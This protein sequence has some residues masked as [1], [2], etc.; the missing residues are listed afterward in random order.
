MSFV[1]NQ[2][3]AHSPLEAGESMNARLVYF[4]GPSGAGKDSLMHW[5]AKHPPDGQRLHL[6]RRTVTRPAP[7]D[8]ATDPATFERLRQAGA[9]AMHW[10]ANGWHYGVRREHLKPL[11]DGDWVLVSGSRAHWPTV[12]SL[13]PGLTGVHV[14][15]SAGVLRQR[16]LERGRESAV[17][18]EARIARAAAL[19]APLGVVSVCNNGVLAEAGEALQNVLLAVV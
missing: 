13:Y 9:L 18:V 6:A 3:E 19:P 2:A 12:Q 4:M 5:L 14:H 17:E 11:T 10:S 7:D 15:A 1:L 16:L 8:E